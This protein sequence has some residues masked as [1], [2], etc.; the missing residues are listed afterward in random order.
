MSR[1]HTGDHAAQ[2]VRQNLRHQRGVGGVAVRGE[3]QL[4][5]LR[6]GEGDHARHQ[7]DEHGSQFQKRSENAAAPRMLLIPARQHALHNVLIGAP[8]PK[9]D[10]GGSWQYRRPRPVG[11]RKRPDEMHS[12]AGRGDGGMF[13]TKTADLG[14]AGGPTLTLELTDAFGPISVHPSP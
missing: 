5:G 13:T 1:M 14:P 6:Q 8:I 4:R 2:P 9:A 12:C 10:D 3:V 7:K 11:I